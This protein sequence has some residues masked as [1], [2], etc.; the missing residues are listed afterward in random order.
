MR[1]IENEEDRKKCAHPP[2]A[3]STQ[4]ILIK[5]LLL[6]RWVN[7]L[8]GIEA[9]L[10]FQSDIGGKPHIGVHPISQLL[11]LNQK[12]APMP[13]NV[14]LKETLCQDFSKVGYVVYAVREGAHF[15]PLHFQYR[16]LL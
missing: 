16:A 5:S 7:T 1:V 2:T 8:R 11:A 14:F 4:S 13:L 3:Q 6:T 12:I 9:I 15:N 10:E